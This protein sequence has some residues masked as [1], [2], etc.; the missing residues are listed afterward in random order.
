MQARGRSLVPR[1]PATD[2]RRCGRSACPAPG[3][4]GSAGSTQWPTRANCSP[5]PMKQ[6]RRIGCYGSFRTRHGASRTSSA[7][8]IARLPCGPACRSTWGAAAR[9]HQPTIA[10]KRGGVATSGDSRRFLLKDGVRYSHILDPGTGWPVESAPRTVTV[11]AQSC[12]QAGMLATLATLVE[13]I[14]P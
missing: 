7:G 8:T 1:T 2:E 14:L 10:L 11:M 12:T 9:A 13:L 4:T 5:M 6:W 3:I